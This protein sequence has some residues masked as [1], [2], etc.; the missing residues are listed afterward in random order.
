MM[1]LKI[2]RRRRRRRVLAGMA[3]EIA[4][5][6]F[7]LLLLSVLVPQKEEAKSSENDSGERNPQ[8]PTK[9]LLHLA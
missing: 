1:S 8:N 9:H 7:P 2:G 5:G 3:V 6:V 4:M